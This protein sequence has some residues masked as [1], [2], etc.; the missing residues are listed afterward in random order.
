MHVCEVVPTILLS[1]SNADLSNTIKYPA[2]NDAAA[3]P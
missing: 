3:D 2:H 1:N